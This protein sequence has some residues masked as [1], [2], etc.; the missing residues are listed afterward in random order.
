MPRTRARCAARSQVATI[1]RLLLVRVDGIGDALA[2]APLVAA[3]HNA[4]HELGA[5]LSTRNRDSFAARAFAHVHTIERI[6]WP[7]HGATPVSRLGALDEVRA[8][9]YD[10]ALIASEELDA[11]TFARDARIRRRIGFVNGWEKPFKTLRLRGL[12]SRAVVRPAS[13]A[14]ARE[15]EVETLFRL[16]AGL[17]G[18][19]LPTRNLARLRPLVL[20]GEPAQHGRVVIQLNAKFVASGIDIATFIGIARALE[21]RYPT[22]AVGDDEDFGA[23]YVARSG[24]AFQHPAS[25]AEWKALIAGARA[26]VTPDSGAA[27]VA[28]MLGIPAV[29]LFAR[30]PAAERDA[31]RWRP[32]AAP[33]RALVVNDPASIADHVAAALLEVLAEGEPPA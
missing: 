21:A 1:K 5:L 6:S 4:G 26:V 12:L 27:H 15:H 11:Y 9:S 16:G 2:C 23:A 28:G 25:V 18:E 3:L 7:R 17:H 20:D 22:L 19:A 31:A 14:R 8:L 30:G 24:L 13:A 29:V 33:A 32:W 10:A